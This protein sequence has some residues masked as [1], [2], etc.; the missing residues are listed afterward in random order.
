M[1]EPGLEAKYKAWSLEPKFAPA[2]KA[3]TALAIL[4]R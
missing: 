1:R 4:I 2:T 3:R